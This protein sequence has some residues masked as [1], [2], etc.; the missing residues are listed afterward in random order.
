M[1]GRVIPVRVSLLETTIGPHPTVNG[2][3]VLP[4]MVALSNVLGVALYN[5][6]RARG[7]YARRLDEDVRG[8]LKAER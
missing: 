3:L 1:E 4:S 5:G 7:W 6:F 2:M 8:R